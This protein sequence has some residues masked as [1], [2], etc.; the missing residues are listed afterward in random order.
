M[1]AFINHM[2]LIER[3]VSAAKVTA[4]HTVSILCDYRREACVIA[5][6]KPGDIASA[7]QAIKI[8]PAGYYRTS[9]VWRPSKRTTAAYY[10][11]LH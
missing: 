7:T 4:M 9:T 1:T 11:F 6:G 10:K 3:D 8:R 5:F 2:K